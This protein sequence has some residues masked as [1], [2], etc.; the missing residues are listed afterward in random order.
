MMNLFRFQPRGFIPQ[1]GFV[2]PTLV[3]FDGDATGAALTSSG[4]QA[5]DLFITLASANSSPPPV[6]APSGH[7][8]IGSG[9]FSDQATTDSSIRVAYK[10]ATGANET[11]NGAGSLRST[12]MALRGVDKDN[13]ASLLNYAYAARSGANFIMPSLAAFSR[14][15]VVVAMAKQVSSNTVNLSGMT[16]VH[17]Q[18]AGSGEARSW[19]SGASNTLGS[20][21]AELSSYGG[22]SIALSVAD[23]GACGFAIWIPGAAAA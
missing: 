16:T 20:A 10:F 18:N 23:V 19:W 21:G 12:S 9:I 8:W 2:L 3:W 11:I 15:G 14:L 22:E 7:T 4:T 5:D 17:T 6:T 13:F 1:A